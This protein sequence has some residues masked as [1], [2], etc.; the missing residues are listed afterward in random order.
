L[1]RGLSTKSALRLI[2]F[3]PLIKLEM[4]R[5]YKNT[6]EFGLFNCDVSAFGGLI[7]Y[8]SNLMN[9]NL[10]LCGDGY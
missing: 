3:K 1:K 4:I 7:K 5:D 6:R 2:S 10:T 8:Y 9:L